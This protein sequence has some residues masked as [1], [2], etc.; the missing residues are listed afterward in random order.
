MKKLLLFLII[1]SYLNVF[2]QNKTSKFYIDPNDPAYAD[3]LKGFDMQELMEHLT[4]FKGNENEKQQHIERVKRAFIDRKY[5]LGVYAA[6]KINARN[7]GNQS[8]EALNCTNIDFES[9]NTSGWTVTGDNAIMSGAGTDA[10]GNFPVVFG[11]NYSLQLSSNNTSTSN[12]Q[13]SATRVISV[14]GANSFF[15][16]HFAL[17]ILDYPHNQAAAAKFT[18][19][20]FD[21]SGAQLPCPQYECYYYQNSAN[22]GTSVGISSFQQTPG[23]PGVNLGGQAFPVTYATWQT[24]AMDLS[25]YSGQSITC[26]I[27]C[28]WC[29]YNYDWAYCYIDADC[30]TSNVS[31][32]ATCGTLPFNLSG[33]TGM[34]SYS[35][36]AP[37]GNSPP[38]A[39]T[40][41]INANIAGTYTLNCTL[42][43]C[44]VTAYTYTYNVQPGPTP[45]FVD[46]AIPC[47]GNLTFTNTST[48]NGGPPITGYTWEWGDGTPHET[49]PNA[50]HT[51]NTA[52]T[53]T[54][55]LV[56]TNGTCIDS[57]S[58]TVVIPAHPVAGFN[59]ANNCLNAVSSYTS[60]STASAGIASQAWN[61]GDNTSGMGATPTHNYALAGTYSVTLVVTDNNSCKDSITKPITIN[62]LPP[63]AVNSSTICIGQQTAT[64]TATGAATYSW[65]PTTNLTPTSG[66]PVTGNPAATT[67]YTVTGTDANGCINTA[68]ANIVVN[69]L[70]TIAVNSATICLGQQ[71]ATLTAT[72]ASTY[73]WSPTTGLIPSSGSPVTGAPTTTTIY[74]VTGTDANGCVNTATTSI[75]V[76][77]L[78]TIAVNSST[79][80]LGEQTAT[81]TATGA[82]T[83][84]WNPTTGLTPTSGSPVT[85]APTAT[86]IYT[87]TGT[88]ANGCTNTA[89]ATITVNPLPP[90]AVNSSTICIG[91]QT[92]TLT[93]TGAT[94]YS[95]NPSNTLSSNSGSPVVGTTTVTSDYTVTGT[96]ANGC[97]NTATTTITIN[98][99]PPVAVNSATICVGQQTA[100]LTA[101]GATTYNWN[102]TIGL[103]PTSGSPVTGTPTATTVYTVTG[104][105]GNGCVNT[106]TTSITVNSLP[107]PT[108]TSN[109]PCVSQ[110]T[111]LLNCPLN[112]M[113]TYAWSGPNSYTAAVQS[114]TIAVIDVTASAAGI[115]TVLVTDNN[116]CINTATVNVTVNPLPVVTVNSPTVCQNQTINLTANGGVNY[117]WSGPNA[118]TSSSQN[119][120]IPN[121]TTS[122]AGSY[123][124]TVKD[125]NGCIGGN[126]AQVVVNVLPTLIVNT[127]TICMGQETA[128]L[129]AGGA[130]TY[131]WAPANTL[132]SN[133]GSVVTGTPAT[134]T[135]YTITATDN[136]GCIN[137]TT[138]TIFVRALP[139][140]TTGSITPA[141]VPLCI[142]LTGT[143]SPAAS[144]YVW[145]FG[146][147]QYDSAFVNPAL[148]SFTTAKC[149]TV[150]G[151]FP[152]KLTVT[153]IYS[154]VSTATTVA[155]AYPLALADFDFGP[156]PITIAEPT[157]QFTNQSSG[158]IANYN[159]D[160]GDTYNSGTD[161]SQLINPA[162]TYS[163]VGSYSVTLE[164][165]T[166]QGCTSKVIKPLVVNEIFV[167]YVPNAFTPNG[168]DVNDMFKAVGEGISKFKLYI[169]DRWGNMLFQSDDIN[170]AWD[171][172]YQTRGGTEILQEDVYVW[173]IEVTDFT[174]KSHPMHGT[175]TLLK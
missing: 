5:K 9:G 60:T 108:A 137:D 158:I 16:L 88:D 148:S 56:I 114:P 37:S 145:S 106:A 170:K 41:T 101:T 131:T 57:I 104:T 73:N 4:T 78:P 23:S 121:A 69:P 140:I 12:F 58:K 53:N 62:P 147:G 151:T 20:F 89:T 35:W 132:S 38:T 165:T 67:M 112:N 1:V 167:I 124:A 109:T 68:T 122:M 97:T 134:T 10:F 74:T 26:K 96:D 169:F 80:C 64:L 61:F 172:T 51:F 144:K 105:D 32:V 128:T 95:W 125:G 83:Y 110:Q 102:P 27:E 63:V 141:C 152:I 34:D 171:G 39:S 24:V 113:A 100:T 103:T 135:N 146:S 154:C 175:V 136:N 117:S 71:T 70:P 33:P 3:S 87:V 161:T 149:F 30:P 19:N 79:I 162:Y 142:N 93:A 163:N 157:V 75:T 99:L 81:L 45:D 55:T 44:S 168:D 17:D 155:I 42:N 130:S 2:S 8:T 160:F 65:N 174:N 84:N 91:Q 156:Q 138:T 52:G 126:V 47:S 107:M 85:G 116:T 59:V 13:S 159:W 92:A 111:I 143:S 166:A 46:A 18:V 49:T 94:S 82:S 72:G 120:S 153:D 22:V 66:S 98:P 40:P 25:A 36:T 115:Y 15:K 6:P 7:N 76:N 48:A 129:T 139:A 54:V 86:T 28:D 29:I 164:V 150:S 133:T 14:S 77:P 31:P 119:P 50:T 43:T 127:D 21:A 123:V 118:Y 173:K 90:V 11:G